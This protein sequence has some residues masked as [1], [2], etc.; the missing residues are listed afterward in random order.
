MTFRKSLLLLKIQFLER[1]ALAM[2]GCCRTDQKYQGP[3]MIMHVCMSRTQSSSEHLIPL[4]ASVVVTQISDSMFATS[5]SLAVCCISLSHCLIPANTVP[6]IASF[7][8]FRQLAGVPVYDTQLG[9]WALAFNSSS[10]EFRHFKKMP[11]P[12]YLN[13]AARRMLS[14]ACPSMQDSG[15]KTT[16]SHHSPAPACL[17]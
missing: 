5:I 3:C 12:Q 14:L 13:H 9:G 4:T 2:S 15:G 8:S 17:R 7:D 11:A 6:I 10:S 1:A 16:S